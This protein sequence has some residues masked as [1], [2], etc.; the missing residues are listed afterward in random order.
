MPVYVAI[1]G[2][3]QTLIEIRDAR[4]HENTCHSARGF[5]TNTA[6]VGANYRHMILGFFP[7][8]WPKESDRESDRERTGWSTCASR[9]SNSMY[10]Y[11]THMHAGLKKP[12]HT[13]RSATASV[14]VPT[15]KPRPRRLRCFVTEKIERSQQMNT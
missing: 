6:C 1:A 14:K 7:H 12:T 15:V 8:H 5:R 9:H 13:Q 3:T 2:H 4:V 11:T 10:K